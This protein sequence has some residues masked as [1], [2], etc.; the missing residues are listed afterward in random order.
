MPLSEFEIARIQRLTDAFAGTY[1]RPDLKITY[2][3]EWIGSQSL[4][5]RQHRIGFRETAVVL[6]IAKLRYVKSARHWVLYW[7]RASGRWHPYEPDI[8]P[9]LEVALD[10]VR[11]D[12]FGCFFG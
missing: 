12:R 9:Q 10:A 2:D 3:W 5:F 11:V 1:S 4:I 6:P 8:Y 7:Q